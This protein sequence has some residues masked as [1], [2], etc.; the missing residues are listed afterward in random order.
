VGI[1]DVSN[2]SYP[3]NQHNPA[4]AIPVYLVA[5]PTPDGKGRFSNA[6][7]NANAAIPVHITGTVAPALV[8]RYPNDQHNPAGAI[9][10]KVLSAPSTAW[11]VSDQGQ[12]TGAIPV[13]DV[14]ALP[15]ELLLYP[16]IQSMVNA[17]IPVWR[18]N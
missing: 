4:G 12:S 14:G 13:W 7:N 5:A 11:G 1:N 16:N 2:F 10:V 6:K 15:P 3:N 9:P 18:V 17:A 8:P